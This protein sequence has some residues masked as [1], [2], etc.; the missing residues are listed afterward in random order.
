MNWD[1]RSFNLPILAMEQ[2]KVHGN[3]VDKEVASQTHQE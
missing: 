3:N 2:C 1:D